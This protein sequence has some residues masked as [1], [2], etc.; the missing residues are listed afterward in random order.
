MKIVFNENSVEIDANPSINHD[1]F[2]DSLFVA[3]KKVE[4]KYILWDDTFLNDDNNMI[5]HV[6]RVFAYELYHQWSKLR[7]ES[8]ILKNFIINGKLS[9]DMYLDKS[10]RIFPDMVLHG[11]QGNNTENKI[12][13][14]I[15]RSANKHICEYIKDIANIKKLTG[16]FTRKS[17][18]GKESKVNGYKHGVLIIEG[19]E[20]QERFNELS[21]HKDFRKYSDYIVI[22]YNGEKM[23][24][25]QM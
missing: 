20:S 17:S 21:L 22:L 12:V 16:E 24:V 4:R 25:Y 5:S 8:E 15:K 14:E 9:K 13:I 18:E 11:G 10:E 3:I 1:E 6:E 19:Y 2:L 7:E 23:S